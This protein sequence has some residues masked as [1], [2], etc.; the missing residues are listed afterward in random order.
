MSGWEIFDRLCRC[1]D[2]EGEVSALPDQQLHDLRAALA[3]IKPTEG[4]PAV[5]SAVATIVA[6][7][8]WQG[9]DE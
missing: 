1:A 6:A 5:I 3:R 2:I 4:I 7:D 8:R 9:G